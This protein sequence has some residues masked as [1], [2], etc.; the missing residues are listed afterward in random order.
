MSLLVNGV[1]PTGSPSMTTSAPDGVEVIL[2]RGRRRRLGRLGGLRVLSPS[3]AFS[4]S[5][6]PVFSPSAGLAAFHLRPWRLP[7]PV[8]R[9]PRRPAGA[10]RRHPRPASRPRRA[11]AAAGGAGAP[12]AAV[13]SP[14]GLAPWPL[15]PGALAR[16]SCLGLRSSGFFGLAALSAS[17]PPV[18]FGA[19][20]CRSVPSPARPSPPSVPPRAAAA[21]ASFRRGGVGRRRRGALCGSDRRRRRG[22]RQRLG[23]A[24]LAL[25]LD[26]EAGTR[27]RRRRRARSRPQRRH[28]RA[29]ACS[30]F[31]A[32][33][34]RSRSPPADLRGDS[35]RHRR[36]RLEA[37]SP[38]LLDGGSG[39]LAAGAVP[40]STSDASGA[41]RIAASA[42]RRGC[43]VRLASRPRASTQSPLA[44]STDRRSVRSP[45]LVETG[46]PV[47]GRTCALAG[48]RRRCAENSSRRAIEHPRRLVDRRLDVGEARSRSMHGVGGDGGTT[49]AVRA[50]SSRT[51]SA[52]SMSSAVGG[53]NSAE[54]RRA[55]RRMPLVARGRREDRCFRARRLRAGAERGVDPG[56]GIWP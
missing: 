14:A 49:G 3:A 8:S 42:R 55:Q 15:F 18:G 40:E 46:T 5:G 45:S 44:G 43:A 30:A 56:L 33:P 50:L 37:W 31:A 1:V 41:S 26:V 53:S 29:D 34:V 21:G 22:G 48:D 32:E 4:P 36:A 39:G 51:D 20:S 7:R 54:R 23:R 25:L 38:G 11:S 10:S 47:S 13:S 16:P 19:A 24:L 12:S 35:H 9:R 17:S 52:L 28:C 6:L 27:D 2:T